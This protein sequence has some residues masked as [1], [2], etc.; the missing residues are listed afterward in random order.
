MP[1][2]EEIRGSGFYKRAM[3]EFDPRPLRE[4]ISLA[5]GAIKQR[6]ATLDPC[7]EN[8]RLTRDLAMRAEI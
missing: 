1:P 2:H 6:L 4:R 8:Q 5:N 7:T 3:L